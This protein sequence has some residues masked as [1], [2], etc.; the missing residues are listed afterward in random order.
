MVAPSTKQETQTINFQGLSISLRKAKGKYMRLSIA[1]YPKA[2]AKQAPL[3]TLF[4]HKKATHYDINT[5]LEN[6]ALWIHNTFRQISLKLEQYNTILANHPNEILLFGEWIPKIPLAHV[7]SILL[8]YLME[9]ATILADS[10]GVR[11]S[12]LGIRP[13][14]TR[15][16]S[17]TQDRLSFSLLLAFAPKE[18]IDY[19]IIHELAHL[20]HKNHSP[21]FWLLVE[22]HCPE[23]RTLRKTL[24]DHSGIYRALLDSIK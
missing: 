14:Y 11:F 16:G 22:K 20:I 5:F 7:R 17:C 12:K 10:L 13:S 18:Q 6:N 4:Y 23:W 21:R 8:A 1:M 15:F 9:R 24:K 19:V 2:K 3:I